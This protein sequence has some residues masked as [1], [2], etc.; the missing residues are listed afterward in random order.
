MNLQVEILYDAEFLDYKCDPKL[1]PQNRG[2]KLFR[3]S[4]VIKLIS[5]P[6]KNVN[7]TFLCHSFLYF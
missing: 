6:Q 5:L 3:L 4:K 2:N 1:L 7:I